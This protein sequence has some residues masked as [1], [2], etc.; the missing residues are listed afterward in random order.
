MAPVAVTFQQVEDIVTSRCS[1]CHAAQPVWAGIQQPP[2]GILL[3]TPARI[4]A[5]AREIA[6]SAAWSSAMPPSNITGITADE[7]E[8]LAL[9]L[10]ARR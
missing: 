9:W 5:H 2:K 3:D 6:V 1:M 4:R 7:R 10:A 8:T